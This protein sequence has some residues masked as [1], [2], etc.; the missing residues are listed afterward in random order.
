M[1]KEQANCHCGNI[2]A[3]VTL[4][5]DLSAYSP[6]ACDCDFCIKNGAAYISD[7]KGKLK[8]HIVE[9]EQVSRYKQ[10]DNLVELLICR[11]CGVLVSVSYAL[12]GKVFGGLNSKTL[13][14]RDKLAPSLVASPKLL[15]SSEKIQRWKDIWFPDV[16]MENQNG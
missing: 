2:T 7:P 11:K 9:P 6:R 10:G 4:T 14:N 1:N 5:A 13:V 16:I 3:E 12:E 15:S 8:I